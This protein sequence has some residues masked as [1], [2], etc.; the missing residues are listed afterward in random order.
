MVERLDQAAVEAEKLAEATVWAAKE[1]RRKAEEARRKAEEAKQKA[2]EAK[3]KA[4]EAKQK[5]EEAKQAA[6]EAAAQ[7]AVA[8]EAAAQEAAAQV[9]A[10]S[11]KKTPV[12]GLKEEEILLSPTGKP[13]TK[14]YFYD[15]YRLQ[16]MVGDVVCYDKGDGDG[17]EYTVMKGNGRED[18]NPGI[19][20]RHAEGDVTN[21]NVQN[22]TLVR[23]SSDPPTRDRRK[24]K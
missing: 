24:E 7:E 1:A 22:V 21:P 11:P 3:Q 13:S 16:C 8:Q 10:A 18:D 9:A 12:K 15:G 17:R 6:Q 23:R 14:R 2:E 20:I 4:E 19:T 5:A